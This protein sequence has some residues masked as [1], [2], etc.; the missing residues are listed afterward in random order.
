MYSKLD[1]KNPMQNITKTFFKRLV[2][3]QITIL[4]ARFKSLER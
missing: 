1:G 4:Q 3:C 2:R